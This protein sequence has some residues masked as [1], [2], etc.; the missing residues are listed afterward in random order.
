MRSGLASALAIALSAMPLACLASALDQDALVRELQSR[1]VVGWPGAQVAKYS[2]L[3]VQTKF[4]GYVVFGDQAKLG[5]ALCAQKPKG[6]WFLMD[7]EGGAVNRID[8]ALGPAKAAP[9]DFS[10]Y[11]AQWAQDASRIASMCVDAVLGP[12]VDTTM[13]GYGRS[14]TPDFATNWT[15]AKPLMRIAGERGVQS[16]LK[17]YPGSVGRCRRV[18]Q[19]KEVFSCDPDLAAVKAMWSGVDW[20]GVKYVMTSFN[21]FDAIAGGYGFVNKPLMSA[22]RKDLGFSG[23]TITDS[24]TELPA[25][26]SNEKLQV[27]LFRYNDMVMILDDG[28]ALEVVERVAQEMVRDPQLLRGHRLSLERIAAAAK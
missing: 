13:D 14:F 27:D 10:A 17:H 18:G 2:G 3:G 26:E 11:S 24:I 8:S 21:R 20:S 5:R 22:L 23:V 9:K 19:S 4:G 15:Y 6:A 28:L 12:M 1:V 25:I 7:H 16:V